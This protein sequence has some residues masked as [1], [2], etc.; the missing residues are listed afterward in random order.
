MLFNNE[1]LEKVKEQ[2]DL[3]ELVGKKV[4]W[5]AKKSKP[6]KG[7]FWAPCPFHSEKTASFHVDNEKG[8]YYCFGC[9]AKGNCFKFV[10]ETE[11]ITTS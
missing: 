10:Q 5:D 1:F 2:V 8:F 4:S 9:H 6:S 11:N 3:A 7:D